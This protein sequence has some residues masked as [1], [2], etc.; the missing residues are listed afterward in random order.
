MVHSGV[1]LSRLSFEMLRPISLGDWD[2]VKD[3]DV[4]VDT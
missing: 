2:R 1:S 4:V 3:G